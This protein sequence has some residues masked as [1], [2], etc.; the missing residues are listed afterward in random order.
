[1]PHIHDLFDFVVT[2]YIVYGRKVL[3]VNHRLLKKWV[4]AGGHI[5]LDENPDQALEREI[6]EE[7]GLD[8]EWPEKTPRGEPSETIPLYAPDYLDVHRFSEKHNHI[9]LNYFL[10]AKSDAVR[11]AEK[12]HYDI[13]WFAEEDLDK[14]EFNLEPPIKFYAREALKKLGW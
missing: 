13:R 10:K 2:F 14:P 4:P 12:E 7:T 11:L 1:M 8:I 6:W 5:E 9:S 3:L